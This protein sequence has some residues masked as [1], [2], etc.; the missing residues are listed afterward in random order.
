MELSRRTCLKAAALPVLAGPN[1]S[2]AAATAPAAAPQPIMRLPAKGAF[3]LAKS[4]SFCASNVR[5]ALGNLT[6]IKGETQ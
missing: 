3:A 4:G 5:P 6:C 1:L 2:A